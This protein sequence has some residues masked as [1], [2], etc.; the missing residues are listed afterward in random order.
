MKTL[1]TYRFE[2]YLISFM[3]ILFGDLFFPERI[4][5]SYINP[6]LSL[7]ALAAGYVILSVRK[8]TR[9]LYGTLF[10]IA[11]ISQVLQLFEVGQDIHSIRVAHYFIFAAF[12]TMVTATII[13]QVWKTKQ[14]NDN[15]IFGVMGGYISLG[16]VAFFLLLGIEYAEPQ[17][18]QGINPEGSSLY[19]DLLYFAY[20]TLMTIGYG[21]IAPVGALARKAAVLIGLW[22]QFYLVIITALVVGKYL[23]SEQGNKKGR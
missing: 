17:S 21:D 8:K 16:L 3:L 22:G 6:L 2:I 23:T 9:L 7:L 14:V 19:K 11:L 20:I 13:I 4:F 15:L 1:R 10:F 5:S 18:F 12:F